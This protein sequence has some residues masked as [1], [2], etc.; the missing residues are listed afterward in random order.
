MAS[1]IR[2][3]R[4]LPIAR[5]ARPAA[6]AAPRAFST[7]IARLAGQGPPQL[8]GEGAKAGTIPTELVFRWECGLVVL[9]HV[10]MGHG[11]QE[12]AEAEDANRGERQK[13]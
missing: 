10:E 8:L 2:S 9:V 7:S 11:A 5:L 6:P 1:V 12:W 3:L 13:V 4:A